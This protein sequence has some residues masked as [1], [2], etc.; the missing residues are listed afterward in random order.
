MRLFK[1]D[2]C[3]MRF[4][5][6][7]ASGQPEYPHVQFSCDYSQQSEASSGRTFTLTLLGIPFAVLFFKIS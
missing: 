2:V 7:I 3:V 1:H 5:A 4:K 6:G